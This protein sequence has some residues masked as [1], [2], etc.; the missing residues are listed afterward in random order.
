M[1]EEAERKDRGGLAAA[2]ALYLVVGFVGSAGTLSAAESRSWP[3]A[4]YY[5][6]VAHPGDTVAR[7]AVR[8]RVSVSAI[9]RLNQLNSVR[10]IRSGRVLRIPAATHATRK[11]ILSEAVDRFAPNYSRGPKPPILARYSVP[12]RAPVKALVRAARHP[13]AE[14]EASAAQNRNGR[15]FVWPLAGTVISYFGPDQHGARND[16][17]N[18]AAEPGVPFRAAAPGTVCYAGA[19]RGYGNLILI[20]HPNG[21]VTAYAH[22]D[23]IA[24]ARGDEVRRGQVIGTAGKTGGVDRP[25]L[26]FEIRRG[27]TP[28]D[29]RLLLAANT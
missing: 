2:A 8:Y 6:V 14:R 7:I 25:Q 9:D 20:T 27:I 22:A 3:R 24:V 17:I 18:I 12:F 5:T 26:H 21:Y 10:R 11:A 13:P 15:Q 29:P 4:T 1:R 19:L 16:G 28:I 23:N